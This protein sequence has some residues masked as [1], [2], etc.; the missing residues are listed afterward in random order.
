MSNL[1]GLSLGPDSLRGRCHRCLFY[2]GYNKPV[3]SSLVATAVDEQAVRGVLV[4]R[5][6]LRQ[7]FDV[8]T[9]I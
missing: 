3:A 6:D 1:L 7:V 8:L 5:I 4:Y 2:R 9:V